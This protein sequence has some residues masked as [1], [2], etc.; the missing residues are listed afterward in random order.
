MKSYDLSQPTA[1]SQKFNIIPKKVFLTS[2]VGTHR[3]ELI[4]FELALR[5]A[6]IE[7]FNLVPV[8]SI[9]PPGCKIVSI[10]DGLKEMHPGQIAFCVMARKTSNETGKKIFASIGVAIPEDDSLHGY[11]AE[12]SGEC[13]EN[14]EDIG[15][16]AEDMASYMVKTAFGIESIKTF[17]VTKTADVRGYTTVIATAVFVF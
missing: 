8:S 4:S 15:R 17:N 14:L 11:I 6:K 10:E 5:D 16:H 13:K 7:K 2:G 1:P 12:Y 3:D 9:L